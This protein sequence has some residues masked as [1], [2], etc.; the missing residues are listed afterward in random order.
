MTWRATAEALRSLGYPRVETPDACAWDVGSPYYAA[1]A[2]RIAGALGAEP[3]LLIGHSGAGGLLPAIADALPGGAGGMVFVDAILPHPGKTWFETAPPDLSARLRERAT[4]GRIP[5]WPEWF[6]APVLTGLLPDADVRAAFS[7]EA[8]PI[9]ASYLAEPAPATRVAPSTRC[10]YLQLSAGYEAE[11]SAAVA[12]GWTVT[13]H[14]SHHLAILT[15]P[16][17]V[18]G[19]LHGLIQD[20]SVPSES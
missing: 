11:A 16:I 5:P 12:A 7:D 10:A 2:G 8:R 9:P 1:L 13:R 15:D 19:A 20:L 3:W 17:G 6:P 4:D 14:S 18:A